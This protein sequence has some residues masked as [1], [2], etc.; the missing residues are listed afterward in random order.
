MAC[1]FGALRA[2]SRCLTLPLSLVGELGIAVVPAMAFVVWSLF[3]IQVCL[4]P[5]LR[6]LSALTARAGQCVLGRS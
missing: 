5:S 1:V 4:L 6:E 2:W 3:G